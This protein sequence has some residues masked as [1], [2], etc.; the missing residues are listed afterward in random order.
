[1]IFFPGTFAP[2]P[3][4]FNDSKFEWRSATCI[5]KTRYWKWRKSK[6]K[7][8]VDKIYFRKHFRFYFSPAF[9]SLSMLCSPVF[10]IFHSFPVLFTIPS[11]IYC[12]IYSTFFFIPC[13]ISFY[14]IH[15]FWSAD[16]LNSF[17]LFFIFKCLTA[18][19]VNWFKY[20]SLH[21]IL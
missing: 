11:V 12:F 16:L 2:P 15:F 6:N 9:Y 8:Q 14:F 18:R 20:F 5:G 13:I 19:R 3:F 4:R 10:I 1:M 17:A 21:F 7:L